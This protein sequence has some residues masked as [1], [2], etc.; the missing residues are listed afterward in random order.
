MWNTLLAKLLGVGKSLIIALAPVLAG[1]LADLLKKTLEK[2]VAFVQKAAADP[3]LLTGEARHAWVVSEVT[4][5]LGE[6]AKDVIPA[7]RDA[8]INLGVKSAY[9]NSVKK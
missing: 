2:A 6:T 8:V 5:L 3:T 4:P 7:V 9:D 1:A